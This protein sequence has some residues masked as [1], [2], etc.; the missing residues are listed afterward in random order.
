[1]EHG[2]NMNG[3][4]SVVSSTWEEPCAGKLE[5]VVLVTAIYITCLGPLAAN[6]ASW[7][8]VSSSS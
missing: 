5:T 7:A 3:R 6:V 2:P 1:M 8:S 4:E